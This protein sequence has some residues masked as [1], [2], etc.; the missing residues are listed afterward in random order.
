MKKFHP[1]GINASIRN[2]FHELFVADEADALHAVTLGQRQHLGY[3]VVVG[4]AIGPHVQLGLRLLRRLDAEVTFQVAQLHHIAVPDDGAVEVHVQA[5]RLGDLVVGGGLLFWRGMSSFTA[6]VITGSVMMN[7]INN[8]NMTSINGVV[9]I[10]IIGA[11]SSLPPT[12]I[13]M[14]RYLSLILAVL[15]AA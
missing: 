4:A 6:C 11:P 14:K 2:L 12:L 5:D 3:G 1:V 7:M 15:A 9:L 13:D 10:S 8:T